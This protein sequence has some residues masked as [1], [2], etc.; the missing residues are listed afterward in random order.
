MSRIRIYM[1]AFSLM[2]LMLLSGC[3]RKAESYNIL[4]AGL[5]QDGI[6]SAEAKGRNGSFSVSVKIEDGFISAIRAGDNSETPARGGKAISVMLPEMIAAQSYDV[7]IV[8]GA[9]ITSDALRSAV[10]KALEEAS[11]S[12]LEN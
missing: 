8:S 4:K 2:L 12:T 7:D 10:A 11:L 1:S 9:T 5:W 3:S 6:Y